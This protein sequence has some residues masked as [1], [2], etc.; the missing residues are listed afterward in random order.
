MKKKLGQLEL[1]KVTIANLNEQEMAGVRGGTTPATPT[2]ID[3][4]ALSLAGYSVG[5]EQSW[6][7]CNT[8]DPYATVTQRMVTYPDQ[9]EPVCELPAAYVYGVRP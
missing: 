9:T 8:P 7:N 2:I 4:V 6:F 3:S 1:K 5:V